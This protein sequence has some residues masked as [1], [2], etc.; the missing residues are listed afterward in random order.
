[1]DWMVD[2]VMQKVFAWK[3]VARYYPEQL[4]D[5]WIYGK[6]TVKIQYNIW[7]MFNKLGCDKIYEVTS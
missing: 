6:L 1:M 5:S 7:P 4:K 3:W 2:S